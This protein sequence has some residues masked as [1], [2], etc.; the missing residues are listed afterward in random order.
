[1]IYD[2]ISSYNNKDNLSLEKFQNVINIFNKKIVENSIN[3]E[4][5]RRNIRSS[6]TYTTNKKAVKILLY[7]LEYMD[8]QWNV[9]F[10]KLFWILRLGKKGREYPYSKY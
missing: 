5:I 7:F 3:Y 9:D 6:V 8:D 2:R 1:M 10:N 4:T